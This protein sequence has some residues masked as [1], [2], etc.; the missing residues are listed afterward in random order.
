MKGSFSYRR[1]P[2]GG[3]ELW[4]AAPT[5]Y[6]G[7]PRVP[8]SRSEQSTPKEGL[9]N[10]DTQHVCGEVRS[11]SVVAGQRFRCDLKFKA[12]FMKQSKRK[13]DPLADNAESAAPDASPNV[14]TAPMSAALG[15]SE[16]R[17]F[18]FPASC[19]VRDSIGLHAALVEIHEEPSPITLDVS[20]VE[21]IDTAM[22]QVLCAFVRDRRALGASVDFIGYPEPFAEA[23]QLLGLAKALG[24][25]HVQV[26]A[27]VDAAPA[28]GAAA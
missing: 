18:V 25:E 24:L 28:R 19:T 9:R 11:R 17:R 4:V 26:T 15:V 13:R 8:A 6:A 21:R 27:G 20:A 5:A 3:I 22:M 14:P 16:Q 7:F 1:E 10:A 12:K 23:V 2:D